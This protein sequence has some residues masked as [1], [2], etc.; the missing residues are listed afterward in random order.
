ML[1]F[2]FFE[3]KSNSQEDGSWGEK[4]VLGCTL[5]FEHLGHGVFSD[6]LFL[7]S[8][9]LMKFCHN[10]VNKKVLPK[11]T[12]SCCQRNR[13]PKPTLIAR[14]IHNPEKR[15]CVPRRSKEGKKNT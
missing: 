2:Q 3:G 1:N 12:V 5:L 13:G 15:T 9:L 11:R 4:I 6:R 14:N 10:F 7:Q 8:T